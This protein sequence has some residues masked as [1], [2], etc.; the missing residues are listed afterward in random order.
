MTMPELLVA[1][2]QS[3]PWARNDQAF[4]FLMN[5]NSIEESSVESPEI[6]YGEDMSVSSD[7]HDTDDNEDQED[8]SSEELLPWEED[9]VGSQDTQDTQTDE[10]NQNTSNK[11]KKEHNEALQHTH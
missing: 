6:Q 3:S 4:D 7:R 2:H 1:Y 11:Q 9:N 5:L 8:E 10:N